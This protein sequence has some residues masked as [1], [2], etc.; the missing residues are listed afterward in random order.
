MLE[1]L[2]PASTNHLT[3][4][5]RV[6]AELSISGSGEDARLLTLI[7]E[8]SDLIAAYCNRDTFGAQE[9]LQTERLSC[10]SPHIVLQRDIV[11]SIDEVEVDGV[12]LAATEYERDGSL[13]YRLQ[14]DARIWWAGK[15]KITFTAGFTLLGDL[16][17]GIERAA[18]DIVVNLYNSAGRDTSI[19]QEMV[20]GVG[21]IAYSDLRSN[22]G[23]PLSAERIRALERYRTGHIR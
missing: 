17:Q 20:Q 11:V 12:L 15:V 4:V 10:P 16:P 8:A 14:D 7:G 22:G 21:S 13:L 18:L 19:R 6:K 9:L 5:D 3:T 2:T 1:I 23:L